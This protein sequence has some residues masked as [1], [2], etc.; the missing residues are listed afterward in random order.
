MADQIVLLITV[1]GMALSLTIA[2]I[3]F[4]WIPVDKNLVLHAQGISWAGILLLVTIIFYVG[5]FTAGV[6]PVAWVGTDSFPSR[7]EH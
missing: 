4:H 3:A 6:A 2:A 7:F 1:M 5:F